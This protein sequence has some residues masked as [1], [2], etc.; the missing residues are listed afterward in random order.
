MKN[1]F[2]QFISWLF[3]PLFI[4]TYAFVLFFFTNSYLSYLI[5]FKGKLIIVSVV[6]I[7]SALLP[8]F[9]LM[10]AHRK[11]IIGQLTM[12][13]REDRVLPYIIISLFYY[14]TYY[15]LR[16]LQLPALFDILY[17]L[18]LGANMLIVAT[19]IINFWWKISAHLVAIGGITGAF[20]SISYLLNMPI[21]WIIISLLLIGG[22]IGFARLQLKSHNITQVGLGYIMGVAGMMILLLSLVKS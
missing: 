16:Q 22:L 8:S 12:E 18:I 21:P 15:L 13:S 10:F 9:F 20:I 4:P 17:L 1:R 19:L 6:F 11:K 7:C 5:T 14:L 2:A 3:H